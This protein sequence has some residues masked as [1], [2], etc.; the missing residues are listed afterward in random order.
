VTKLFRLI[1]I[2]LCYISCKSYAAWEPT[3]GQQCDTADIT[4]PWFH[5]LIVTTALSLPIS[6]YYCVTMAAISE[7]YS[8]RV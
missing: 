6:Q 5:H 1:K 2:K 4:A 7:I 8:K 3:W